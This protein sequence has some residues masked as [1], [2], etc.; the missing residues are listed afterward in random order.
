MGFIAD[1]KSVMIDKIIDFALSQ[2]SYGKLWLAGHENLLQSGTSVSNAYEQIAT[3]YKA[4]R[5][6]SDNIPQAELKFYRKGT[7]D[8]ATDR[9]LINLF[10]TPNPLM[11]LNMLL[12]YSVIFYAL[13]G[14]CF[15]VFT[16]SQG[17]RLG[18]GRRLPAEIWT[19]HPKSF[20]EIVREGQLKEWEVNNQR[21]EIENVMHARQANISNMFRGFSQTKPIQKL[22]DID[23][24]T[25]IYNKAFFENNATPGFMLST[26]KSLS[27]PQRKRLKEWWNKRHKGA[28]NAFKA[29]ILEGGLQPKTVGIDHSKM[30]FID[31]K[32]FLREEILGIWRVPKSVFSITD[33]L[34]YATFIG[35]KKI[36]WTDTIIPILNKFRDEINRQF[37]MRFMPEIEA[38]FDYANVVA[39][40]EDF[41]EKVATA[42]ELHGMGYT[43]NE[44]N[45]RLELGFDE[46]P[47]GDVS[48]MPFSLV[49][50]DHL[51]D[52]PE[53]NSSSDGESGNDESAK[54]LEAKQISIA[55]KSFE[56]K[57]FRLEVL[58][59]KKIER[60]FFNQR[61]KILKH[62]EGKKE[63]KAVDI[64]INWGAEEDEFAKLMRQ[65]L[66]SGIDEGFDQG[67]I[68]S[69]ID[70]PNEALDSVKSSFLAFRTDKT[71]EIIRRWGSDIIDLVNNSISQGE[72]INELAM[73]IRTKYNIAS[74]KAKM[75]AR[76]ES[77][78]S[79][80]GGSEIYYREAGFSRKQWITARD[81]HVRES[82]KR[83]HGKIVGLNEKFSNGLDYPGG[84]G[85]AEEVINCRCSILPKK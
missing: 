34:N 67:Q 50:V 11:S 51:M 17:Q 75:I 35:Q 57:Q 22:M 82:H 85:P 1:I 47:W 33:D 45:E 80:N 6:I 18:T 8:E 55:L 23:F 65:F 64:G 19:Y 10:E 59:K 53:P 56:V 25:L 26:D 52:K 61:A 54:S 48:F 66:E 12:E 13:C 14:E 4:I 79:I 15:W 21:F 43:R 3:V 81:E 32:K 29:A 20:K 70:V 76:T 31:Q 24:Q 39:L 63:L 7:E 69:S 40:Q 62:L 49:P 36:F 5:A 16:E 27:D 72:T 28:S 68:V 77:T 83:L 30:E 74:S 38:R 9:D 37:F 42:K 84:E 58:M 71:R 78:G 60:F 73:K 44:I 2:K 41:K 46:V